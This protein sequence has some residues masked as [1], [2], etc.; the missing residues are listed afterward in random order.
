M[1]KGQYH[2]VPRIVIH[3]NPPENPN[4]PTQKRQ[5]NELD[6]IIALLQKSFSIAVMENL[7]FT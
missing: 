2:N 1:V 6:R 4:N 3:G 7:L 5:I